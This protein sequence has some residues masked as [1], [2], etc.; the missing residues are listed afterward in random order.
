MMDAE[1]LHNS[2]LELFGLAASTA[3]CFYP[4]AAYVSVSSSLACGRPDAAAQHSLT[5]AP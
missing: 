4:A 1:T 2:R 5:A 3:G